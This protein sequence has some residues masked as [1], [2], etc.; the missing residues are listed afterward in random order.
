MGETPA[1]FQG[2]AVVSNGR[3][4][5]VVLKGASSVEIRIGSVLRATLS[6]TGSG[7]F[8]RV[9]LVEHGRGGATLEVGG[10]RISARFQEGSLRLT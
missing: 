10:S 8:D 7:K 4:S 1:A 6:L 3:I 5:L 9:A 2:D